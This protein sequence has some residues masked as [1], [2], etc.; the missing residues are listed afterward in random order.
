MR[1]LSNYFLA[2]TKSCPGSSIDDLMV[3]SGFRNV[4]NIYCFKNMRLHQFYIMKCSLK[5]PLATEGKQHQVFAPPH[6]LP[7]IGVRSQEIRFKFV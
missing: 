4:L 1:R 5:Q 6:I 3:K 7:G 2:G